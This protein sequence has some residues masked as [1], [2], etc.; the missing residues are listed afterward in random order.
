M[1]FPNGPPV[2]APAV[3]ARLCCENGAYVANLCNAAPLVGIG[4]PNS[5][6]HHAHQGAS[7]NPAAI[8]AGDERVAGASPDLD[9]CEE[10]DEQERVDASE[11]GEPDDHADRHP[12]P[13]G[14]PVV[15][16]DERR[17][18]TELA[19]HREGGFQPTQRHRRR[20][21]RNRP[22]RR[23][24]DGRD[25]TGESKRDPRQERDDQRV[26]HDEQEQVDA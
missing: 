21:R 19:E 3:N 23:P 22:D 24:Q 14:G 10:R 16:P 25:P 8:D 13:R 1:G 5:A 20:D 26:D 7:V 2:T 6:T 18:E 4:V 17:D 12:S 15:G 11:H 9:E